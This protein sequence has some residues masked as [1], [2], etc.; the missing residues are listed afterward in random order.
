MPH[1]PQV[2]FEQHQPE[3]NQDSSPTSSELG[4][5]EGLLDS[6]PISTNS[7]WSYAT[8]ELLDALPKAWTRG[9]LYLLGAFT[10]IALPWSMLA[11]VD[12]PG[13]AKGRLEPQG[14]VY[15]IDAASSGTITAIYVKEGDLVKTGQSLLQLDSE[16]IK[17]ELQ[18]IRL[19]LSSQ[20]Q[21]QAQLKQQ[22]QAQKTGQQAQIEQVQQ[23]TTASQ[24]ARR[25]TQQKLAIDL[26]EVERYRGLSQ[27]GVIPQVKVIELQRM[28][29][30]SQQQL[31]QAQAEMSQAQSELE[32]QKSIDVK[33]HE[34]FLAQTSN[35]GA[36][37]AQSKS[38][39][40]HLEYQL[41]QLKTPATVDGTVLSL[42]I[43]R[44]GAVVQVGQRLVEIAPQNV[45]LVLRAQIT[46]QDSGFLQLNQEVNIKF[47]A[48][49]YQDYGIVKGH[50]K[51]VSP[52]SKA[53]KT[54][55]GQAE[56]F[57]L[58][59]TLDQ[60]CVSTPQ[61]CKQLTAG[62]TATADVLVRQRRIIDFLLDPFK[63]LQKNGLQL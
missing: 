4:D 50:L 22:Y 5:S 47:D 44:S 57:E 28:A 48:Y 2:L 42:P 35:L 58:E 3:Q 13:V 56:I 38:K 25:L 46:S 8:Q 39:I 1:N 37:I 61:G 60:S 30:E 43:Q 15:T 10:A 18:Q 41:Q 12:V 53:I 24:Q 19:Q 27:Q 32:K 20:I 17:A 29:T 59:I 23:R 14:K 36:E 52:D 26:N 51:R 21:Q 11:K 55:Q 63:K 62:Q 16:S 7:D 45:P 34:E 33:Q 6:T 40:E 31:E 54:E 49:P 9:L